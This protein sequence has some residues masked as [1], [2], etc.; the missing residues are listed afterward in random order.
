MMQTS[1][2]LA[3][4]PFVEITGITLVDFLINLSKNGRRLKARPAQQE[5]L[6]FLENVLRM[7]SQNPKD[8]AK[9]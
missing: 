4:L 1:D 2:Y 9:E 8:Q 7:L 3:F 6:S 5:G